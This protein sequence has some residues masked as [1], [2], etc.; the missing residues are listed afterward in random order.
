[1]FAGGSTIALPHEVPKMKWW[2]QG[3]FTPSSLMP[4]VCKPPP[5][6]MH[7]ESTSIWN[8][9]GGTYTRSGVNRCT[10]MAKYIQS[11]GVHCTVQMGSLTPKWWKDLAKS[12]ESQDSQDLAE[13]LVE[14]FHWEQRGLQCM[15]LGWN[16]T[17]ESE[18]TERYQ[19]RALVHLT[20]WI[21]IQAHTR[22][23]AYRSIKAFMML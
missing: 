14:Q 11:Q 8:I 3:T 4:P 20:T 21:G 13:R 5:V 9:A 15:G 1:M 12:P 17:E 22:Y 6:Q 23:G 16:A 18:V 19:T 2:N 10:V 7:G